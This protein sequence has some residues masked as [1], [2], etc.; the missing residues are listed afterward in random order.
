M[1]SIQSH[2]GGKKLPN[3]MLAISKIPMNTRCDMKSIVVV[4]S[5]ELNHDLAWKIVGS[6]VV[7]VRLVGRPDQKQALELSSYV[8]NRLSITMVQKMAHH[9]DIGHILHARW[10]N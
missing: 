3:W 8:V 7:R 5:L 4:Q 6:A 9:S 10:V 2:W 1:V